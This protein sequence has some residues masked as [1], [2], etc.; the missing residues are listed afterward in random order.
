MYDIRKCSDGNFILAGRQDNMGSRSRAYVSKVNQSG[1]IIW[2]K[3]FSYSNI[4]L[5]A[6]RILELPDSTLLTAGIFNPADG[7][8]TDLH[9]LRLT[10][11]GDSLYG[12][13]V[14]IEGYIN[15]KDIAATSDGG[16]KVLLYQENNPYACVV[17]WM[18]NLGAVTSTQYSFRSY[19]FYIEDGEFTPDGGAILC[20]YLEIDPNVYAGLLIKLDASGRIAWESEFDDPNSSINFNSVIDYLGGGYVIAGARRL[21]LDDSYESLLIRTDENGNVTG[22]P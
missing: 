1:G 4:G 2:Q 5:R 13:V 21:L 17:V 22:A 3:T 8:G 18:D 20:G 12:A 7:S 10:A 19:D 9:I 15:V 14:P 6:E 11:T 16:Y